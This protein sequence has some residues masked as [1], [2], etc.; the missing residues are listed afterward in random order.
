MSTAT[1][2]AA[3]GVFKIANV[4]KSGTE[5][6]STSA[7]KLSLRSLSAINIGF[8]PSEGVVSNTDPQTWSDG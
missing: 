6:G 3:A 8:K 1:E 7:F 2:I 5:I 4:S